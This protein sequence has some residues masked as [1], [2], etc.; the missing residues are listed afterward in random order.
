MGNKVMCFD[1]LE[2]NS[3]GQNLAFAISEMWEGFL[4]GL[5]VGGGLL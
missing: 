5:V 1:V 4:S 2:G 3:A